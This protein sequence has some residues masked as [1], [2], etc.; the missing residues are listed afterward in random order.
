MDE[1]ATTP[2]I[3]TRFD[4]IMIVIGGLIVSSLAFISFGFSFL[5]YP[6]FGAEEIISFLFSAA[7]LIW[8][9]MLVFPKI[10][11]T[12]ARSYRKH[13]FHWVTIP[14]RKYRPLAE[15][16]LKRCDEKYLSGAIC[17]GFA[18]LSYYA[19]S[20][21]GEKTPDW[22]YSL[23]FLGTI[24]WAG[25]GIYTLVPKTMT[26][27]GKI[28]LWLLGAIV[29]CAL[30]YAATQAVSS[31]SIPAAIIIGAIIIARAR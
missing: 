27:V 17:F 21:S 4:R 25:A 28:G 14:I 11:G 1:M 2:R 22:Q 31:L 9:L 6:A 26:T 24:G 13:F 19:L 5:E 3:K 15:S 29:V 16:M 10:I 20:S 23:F 12:R 8:G 30:I 7:A 18:L